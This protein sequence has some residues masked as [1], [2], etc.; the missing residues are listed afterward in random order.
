[1]LLYKYITIFSIL[2]LLY[3]TET[4]TVF[5][6]WKILGTPKQNPTLTLMH[7]YNVYLCFEYILLTQTSTYFCPFVKPV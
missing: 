2:L 4:L 1:M 7:E 6:Q 5:P 3:M